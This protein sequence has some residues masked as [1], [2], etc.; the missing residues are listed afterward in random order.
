MKTHED[1][2]NQTRERV[3]ARFSMAVNSGSTHPDRSTTATDIPGVEI[4]IEKTFWVAFVTDRLHSENSFEVRN[5]SQSFVIMSAENK[6][7]GILKREALEAQHAN[8]A[9]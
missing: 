5:E 6:I 3:E 7:R 8:E 2:P 9:K 1:L 4:T